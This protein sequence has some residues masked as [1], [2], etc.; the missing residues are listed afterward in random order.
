MQEIKDLK[1]LL[2]QTSIH[3]EYAFGKIFQSFSGMVYSFS[4]KLTRSNY[5]AEEIVQEVFLKVWIHR[6]SLPQIDNFSAYLF[7]I[8]KNLAFNI[9]KHNLIEEKAK[10]IL[11]GQRTDS[12]ET[13][14]TVI[15]QD[16]QQLL[17]KA[18]N[19]LPPQQKLV[20]S[21]CHQEGL[22]YKEAAQKLK[23][24][25]LTVKTHMQQALRSIKIQ[26]AGLMRVSVLFIAIYL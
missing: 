16:Y 18:I 25:R 26:F 15:Y 10:T 13:E 24:S 17:N 22:R 7:T 12:H 9:L 14:E 2:Y 11:H 4:Y 21:M 8:A 20:Y 19:H 23:I 1:N 3:D 5:L 6:E